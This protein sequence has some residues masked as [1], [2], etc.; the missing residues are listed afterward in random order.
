MPLPWMTSFIVRARS[1]E[2][3][4]IKYVPCCSKKN[5]DLTKCDFEEIYRNLG[6]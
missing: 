2:I 1:E 5:R 6:R 3:F 4:R